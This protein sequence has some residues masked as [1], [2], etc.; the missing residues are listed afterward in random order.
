M[1]KRAVWRDL[2]YNRRSIKLRITDSISAAR[3]SSPL[4]TWILSI[5]DAQVNPEKIPYFIL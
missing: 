5:V 1:R 4:T 3:S 2:D